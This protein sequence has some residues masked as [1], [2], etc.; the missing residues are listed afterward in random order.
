MRTRYNANPAKST[1]LEQLVENEKGEKKRTATEGLMW[2]LRGLQFTG[3]ALENAQANK[4][5]ELSTA[6]TSAY[7]S[8]LKQ[9]HNFV[10]KGVF[11]VRLS[12]I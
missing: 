11:A 4:Q 9:F 10:I 12:C 3:K 2:L 5:V 8:T 7:E 6:F 1:T